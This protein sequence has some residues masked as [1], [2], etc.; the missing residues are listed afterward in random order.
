MSKTRV[1]ASVDPAGANRLMKKQAHMLDV[2]TPSEFAAAH[3]PDSVNVPLDQL[4]ERREELQRGLTNPVVL[5][6]R[7]GVRAVH[8]QQWL[9]AA[10]IKDLTVLKGGI[11]AWQAAGLPVERSEQ[12]PGFGEHIRD[13]FRRITASSG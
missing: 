1:P 5:I 10:G 12:Q 3:I 9:Q 2:R 8:A 4:A 13:M 7:S 11:I 6:C